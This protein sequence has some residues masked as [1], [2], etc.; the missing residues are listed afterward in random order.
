MRNLPRKDEWVFHGPRG[1]RLKPDTVRNIFVDRVI[2]PLKGRFPND[3]A[4]QRGF[5]DGRLHSFCQ[6]FCSYCANNG[7]PVHVVMEWL[8]H[9]SSDMVRYYYHLSDDESR[10]MMDRLNL[11]GDDDGCSDVGNER[12]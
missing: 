9:A 5:E 10:K 2:K 3:V 4:N 6:Y 7:I 12:N 1:G 8:G 11:L